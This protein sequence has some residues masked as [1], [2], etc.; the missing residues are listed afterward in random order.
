LQRE[1]SILPR[2]GKDGGDA[3]NA[4]KES[5]MKKLGYVVAWF[6][7]ISASVSF[8]QFETGTS[9]NAVCGIWLMTKRQGGRGTIQQAYD[10]GHCQGFVVGAIDAI[11]LEQ[12]TDYTRFSRVCLPS[13][14]DQKDA[15]EIFAV[16]LERHPEQRYLSGYMLVRMA[17]AESF[18]C[19]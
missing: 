18:P 4:G 9:L 7:M 8:A 17:L 11:G 5:V 2:L 14:L 16:Y 6:Y 12:L 19:K 10:T 3:L 15:T 1:Q 13:R